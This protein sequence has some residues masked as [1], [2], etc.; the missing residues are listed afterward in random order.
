MI[1][2]SSPKALPLAPAGRSRF[3]VRS[4]LP[5]RSL[6]NA[7]EKAQLQLTE[8]L[9]PQIV[10]TARFAQSRDRTI[11]SHEWMIGLRT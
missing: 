9:D 2:A 1:N 7:R 6:E 11:Q 4:N 5:G 8:I 10:I 3:H